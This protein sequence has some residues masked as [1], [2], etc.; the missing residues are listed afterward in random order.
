MLHW[1]EIVDLH[2]LGDYHDST[3][4]L[5]GRPFDTD[6]TFRKPFLLC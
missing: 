3:G 5:P 2:I 1:R 6:A 4:M